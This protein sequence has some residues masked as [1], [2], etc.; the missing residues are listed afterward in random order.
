[1]GHAEEWIDGV[2]A[3]AVED[4][5]GWTEK[6]ASESWVGVG[7]LMGEEAVAPGLEELGVEVLL[8]GLLRL[9]GGEGR[10]SESRCCGGR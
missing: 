6:S 8:F 3:A 5:A 2:A 7:G 10:K 9:F 1:V 4:G